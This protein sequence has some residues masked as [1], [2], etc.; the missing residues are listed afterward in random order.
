MR[1]ADISGVFF[2]F[3]LIFLLLPPLVVSQEPETPN[4]G[5]VALWHCARIAGL[6]R[7]LEQVTEAIG[8][9]GEGVTFVKLSQAAQKLG[10]TPHHQQMTWENLSRLRTPGIARVNENEFIVVERAVDEKILTV[11]CSSAHTLLS[12]EAFS[13]V[14]SG[15]ILV[16]KNT[17]LERSV[18]PLQKSPQIVFEETNYNFG[19]IEGDM[20]TS[21]MFRFRNA[22]EGKLVI[23]NVQKG[24]GC[25]AAVVGKKELEPGERSEVNVQFNSRGKRGRQTQKIRIY[26][27]DPSN[28]QVELTMS[29]EV[30]REVYVTPTRVYLGKVPLDKTTTRNVYVFFS[31]K[32]ALKITKVE[33]SSPDISTEVA[34][35]TNP[36]Q[37]PGASNTPSEARWIVKVSL[38]PQSKQGDF[39]EMLKIHTTSKKHPVIEIPVD[40]SIVGDL[41]FLPSKAYFGRVQ[42]GEKA[43][44]TISLVSHSGQEFEILGF[45]LND[46]PIE[47][48][49]DTGQQKATRHIIKLAFLAPDR[50]NIIRGYIE[51]TIKSNTEQTLQLPVLALIRK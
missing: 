37:P 11:D 24:C 14:W 25:T 35:Y 13:A 42:P 39:R 8:V 17:G 3:L 1:G 33:A 41:E 44:R 12:K 51:V 43:E 21:H 6:D 9:E 48:K 29:G 49:V 38:K 27:N 31:S 16:V 5:A 10:L 46:L 22:G 19:T 2:V 28:P 30:E 26:S 50:P 47:A 23:S 20:V 32:P 34:P 40:G 18:P 15:E 45:N 7:S 36:A 4:C